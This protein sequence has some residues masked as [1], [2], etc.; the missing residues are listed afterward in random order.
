M[1]QGQNFYKTY[2]DHIAER[3]PWK[4]QKLAVNAGFTC[5]NRDG[6]IGREGCIY[7]NNA[8]FVPPY[9]NPTHSVTAQ[10]EEGKKF[11]GRKYPSMHYLAYFQAYTST[12][13]PNRHYLLALYEEALNVE[14]VEGLVLST[15]P[16]CID[17]ILLKELSN[18]S[19][20]SGKRVMLE[21]GV[22]TTHDTTLASINRKHDWS[23]ARNAILMAASFGFDICVHLIMGL[24]GEDEEMMLLSVQRVVQLPVTSLKFHQLQIL[25]GTTMASSYEQGD[26]NVELF[27]LDAY[28]DLCAKITRLVPDSIAIERFT[29]SAPAS[30]LIA[31]AWGVKNHEFVHKLNSLLSKKEMPL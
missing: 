4:M 18:L 31:P 19:V 17:S 30:I 27:S 9:C 14:K 22:E 7:C 11:F 29:A 13:S 5:P 21:F 1:M 12:H 25:K 2:S 20:K 3:F 10:L 23:T 15:R 16:D 8:A 28:L 24:P 6:T 26:V